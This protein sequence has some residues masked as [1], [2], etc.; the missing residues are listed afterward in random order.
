[1][2][3]VVAFSEAYIRV[4]DTSIRGD[5]DPPSSPMSGTIGGCRPPPQSGVKATILGLPPQVYGIVDL[6]A[7]STAQPISAAGRRAP[8]GPHIPY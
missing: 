4:M 5:C 2:R 6:T 7:H 3:D 8:T 1:M